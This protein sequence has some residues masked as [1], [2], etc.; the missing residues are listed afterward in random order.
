MEKTLSEITA[1]I[2]RLRRP[3]V[4]CRKLSEERRALDQ[5]QIA[6]KLMEYVADLEA[7][8]ADGGDRRLSEA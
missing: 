6:D 5:V 7:K 3:A 4:K 2:E 8:A 1:D